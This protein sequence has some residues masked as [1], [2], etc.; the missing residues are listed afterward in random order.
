MDT[1]KEKK[2][3]AYPVNAMADTVCLICGEYIGK[4]GYVYRGKTVCKECVDYI[5]MHI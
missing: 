4:Y 3:S 1:A 5:R 2:P